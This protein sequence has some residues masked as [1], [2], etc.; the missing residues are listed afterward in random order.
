MGA[1]D[2]SQAYAFPP[3]LSA[4]F[5]FGFPAGGCNITLFPVRSKGGAF[6]GSWN[7]CVAVGGALTVAPSL[8]E[9]GG[10][11]VGGNDTALWGLRPPPAGGGGGAPWAGPAW[12][13]PFPGGNLSAAPP[14]LLLSSSLVALLS[15]AGEL[16]LL[17]LPAAGGPPPPAASVAGGACAGDSFRAPLTA[18]QLARGLGVVALSSQGCA[19]AFAVDPAARSARLLWSVRPPLGGGGPTGPAVAPPA[20][21][22]TPAGGASVFFALSGALVCCVNGTD[23]GRCGR[24][25][26]APPGGGPVSCVNLT[27]AAGASPP[28]ATGLCASPRSLDYHGGQLYALD[29]AGVLLVVSAATGGAGASSAAAP[30]WAAGALGGGAAPLAAPLLVTNAAGKARDALLLALPGGGPCGGA[31]PAAA[32]CVVALRVGDNAAARDDDDS[33]DDADDDGGATTGAMWLS[34]V[35]GGGGS[36]GGG[37]GAPPTA[38]VTSD[39]H[40]VVAT[41]GGLYVVFISAPPS[42]PAPSNAWL[43]SIAVS[44]VALALLGMAGAL[45]C[46]VRQ[47]RLRSLAVLR[48]ILEAEEALLAG[49]NAF[50]ADGG[51]GV[52]AA[53][54]ADVLVEGGAR[55]PPLPAGGS[56]LQDG[57]GEPAGS[58]R[59]SYAL[60]KL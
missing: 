7:P 1:L 50:A 43:Y 56:L 38:A 9:D 42:D 31:P 3:L 44:M 5:V 54:S 19:A 39:G 16:L 26:A 25:P 21:A 60:K 55:A 46:V 20:V 34:A 17:Q 36:G 35:G 13:V 10:L 23:G 53:V 12:T 6:A 28:L 30:P 48:E 18:L 15:P 40:I 14:P 11:L 57:A 24:W 41:P 27:S 49:E 47:R 32:A 2:A 8:T 58:G 22:G 52:P 37:G 51:E 59:R 29:S 4:E 33:A 45:A